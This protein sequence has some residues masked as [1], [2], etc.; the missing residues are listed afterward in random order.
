MRLL[1]NHGRAVVKREGGGQEALV[2]GDD[3]DLFEFDFLG[4]CVACHQDH[5]D[6]SLAK[7]GLVLLPPSE[8]L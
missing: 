3:T 5:I 8:S 6:S 4:R 1:P 7:D 2:I